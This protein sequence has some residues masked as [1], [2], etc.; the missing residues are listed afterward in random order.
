VLAV[1]LILVLIMLPRVNAYL[2]NRP[3]PIEEISYTDFHQALEAGNVAQVHITQRKISGTYRQP[4]QAQDSSGTPIVY[5]TFST[6]LPEFG[7]DSLTSL[8]I[9]K[10]VVFDTR[11]ETG[12]SWTNIL[13]N[14]LPILLFAVLG[15]FVFRSVNQ[16]QGILPGKRNKAQLYDQ[17]VER[18]TFEDV[19]G[20]RGAKHELQEI[21]EILRDPERYQRLGAATPKGVLLVGPPGT[22]KTLLARAVAGEA[23]VPFYS[24]TG[25]D[26]MEMFVGVG[27][28]RVRELF[29]EAKKHSPCIIFIDEIDSIGRKRNLGSGGAQEE[30]EQTLNQLLSEMDGFRPKEGVIVIAATN[31]PEVL[32]PA[33]LRAG[34]FDRR[35]TVDLPSLNDRVEI[36]RTH[37][38]NKPVSDSVDIESI[39]RGTPGFS[40][41]DLE[42]LLNEAALMAARK[43]KQD[44]E[45]EDFEDAR[46]KILMGLERDSVLMTDEESR[47]IAYHEAGHAIT[48][49]VLP[50]ADPIHKVTIVPRGRAMG[51][52]QQLPEREKYIYPKEYMLDR[53][54]VMMG[55]R[56]AERLIFN[57]ATSGAEN[58]LKQATSLARKMVLDWGMSDRLGNIALGSK[59]EQVF[60]GEETSSRDYSEM[61]AREIDQE[62]RGIVEEAYRRA[63]NLLTERRHQLDDLADLL[64]EKE[65]VSGTEVLRLIGLDEKQITFNSPKSEVLWNQEK[66]EDLEEENPKLAQH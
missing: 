5:Q 28:S 22:G 58:D 25:S 21:I 66:E 31:R 48:A 41:A 9:T 39:A 53:L 54:A 57:T 62:I 50:F 45:P 35:V 17:Q 23:G 55:G 8:L 18:T 30:R 38:R 65:I 34:R 42:N 20:E 27:A 24:I 26:F 10:G 44:I 1:T 43:H 46:D 51:V 13:S 29:H 3:T 37:A 4:V 49:A 2:Q 19:A 52:T 16:G 14:I 63:G 56:A 6:Y 40:G 64:I 33:L 59:T 15:Y 32:D 47:L 7:D 12:F 60:L 11:P 36:L 61:T